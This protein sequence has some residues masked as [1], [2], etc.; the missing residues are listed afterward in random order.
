MP[1]ALGERELGVA[2][3]T[4]LARFPASE[5]AVV[6]PAYNAYEDTLECV[7]S[8]LANTPNSPILVID[9]GSPDDRLG[10]DLR[11]V[12]E[13]RGGCYVRLPV[14]GGF[15]ASSNFAFR[16]CAPRDVILVN[17]DVV[18]PANWLPR[19]RAAA[20]SSSTVATAS[21]LTNHG[22][23]LSVPDRNIPTGSLPNG[24]TVDEV[25]RLINEASLRLRPELPTTVGHCMYIRREALD[26]VGFFDPELAPG[27]GEEVDFS[28]RALAVG[29]MHVAADDL[30]VFH[31]GSRSFSERQE[32]QAYTELRQHH[33]ALINSRYPYYSTWVQAAQRDDRSPLA[34]A[35]ERARGA[36][37]GYRIAIDATRITRLTTGSQVV[38]TELVR[39]LA[40]SPRRRAHMTLIVANNSDETVSWEPGLVDEVIP[41]AQVKAL[42]SAAFDLIFCPVQVSTHSQLDW[43]RRAGKRL[44]VAQLDCIYYG[45]PSYAANYDEWQ[46]YRALTRDVYSLAD[47]ITYLSQSG[48]DEA[49]R[50]GLEVPAERSCVTYLGVNRN[51]RRV[52]SVPPERVKDLAGRTYILLLSTSFKHKNRTFALHLMQVLIERYRWDGL[53]VIAGPRVE[54]GGSEPEEKFLLARHPELQKQVRLVGAIAEK[55]KDW[56]IQNASLVLF[57]SIREG[58]GIVPFEAAALNV[59]AIS[60]RLASLPEVLGEEVMYFDRLDPEAGA[61]LVHSFLE[62]QRLR[63]QQVAAV[64]ARANAFTWERT[65]G[66]TWQ[67]CERLLALP[68]RWLELPELGPVEEELVID[69]PHAHNWP[70][71]IARGYRIWRKYGRKA[72]VAEYHQYM[73]W[74]KMPP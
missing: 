61:E 22:T 39:A 31:R 62:S 38:A 23:L 58:F 37:G 69:E 16:Y 48:L 43:L 46:K 74:R 29:F 44:V 1:E 35:V 47:G 20:Y 51:E 68:P 19:L 34:R 30:F 57:P 24:M 42:D 27:Y 12:L 52:P 25:D 7:G 9:D 67:F 5:A 59:P 28:Q 50:Y 41:V 72:L 63:Q 13:S 60:T 70:E 66:L 65:A 64:Q 4:W 53:M 54:G 21:P 26:T 8:L 32:T 18:V 40:S 55:S 56:L 10:R 49:R 17:S 6:V 11:P 71:R 45:N 15:V 36:L 2:V 14:N 33:E 73:Q 3:Q